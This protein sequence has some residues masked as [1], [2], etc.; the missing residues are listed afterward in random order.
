MLGDADYGDSA[1]SQMPA[2]ILPIGS[3]RAT[4]TGSTSG[5]NVQ[6]Q[7][8]VITAANGAQVAMSY[9]G[10]ASGSGHGLP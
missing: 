7:P 8:D 9:A 2:A 3:G 6:G 10:G 5:T 1:L 4:V